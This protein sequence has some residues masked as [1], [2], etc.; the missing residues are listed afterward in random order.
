MD[1]SPGSTRCPCQIACADAVLLPH[2]LEFERRA[3]WP[4]CARPTAC[5]PARAADRAGLPTASSPVGPA[6][7][8]QPRDGFPPGLQRMLG[9][10]PRAR[11]AAACWATRSCCAA[12]AACT[13]C[14]SAAPAARRPALRRGWFYPLPAGA[15]LLKA[16][17]RLYRLTPLRA[18]LRPGRRWERCLNRPSDA[19]RGHAAGDHLFRRRLPRQSR[20]RRLGRGV[21]SPA[22]SVRELSGCCRA[23]HQQ[24][25]GA[26]G[27]HRGA[28]RAQAP[29]RAPTLYTDSQYVRTGISEWLPAWK[30]RGWRT[31]DSKPVKNQDLWQELDALAAGHEMHWHWVKGHAGVPDNEHVDAAGQCG[32]RCDAVG[33]RLESR[34][35][36][37]RAG[38]RN[39]GPRGQARP[40]HHR[41]RLRGAGQPPPHRP[42]L[43]SLPE[44]GARHR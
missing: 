41:D 14:R 13:P 42:A 7:R 2:T 43:P 29:R 17:K 4:W 11:L 8:R 33:L 44:S 40:P 30:A 35:E 15:C 31:A 23:D 6:R 12:H 28:A 9:G 32:H 10:A 25:H 36:S 34:H 37:D 16:R 27:G 20:T 38:Y 1:S 21:A 19:S 24:P 5:S 18:R 39:H 22:S 3:A 26:A